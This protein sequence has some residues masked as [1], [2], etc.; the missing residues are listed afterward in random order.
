MAKNTGEVHGFLGRYQGRRLGTLG[1][2]ATLS[3]HETKNIT[4]G[5]GGALLVNDA[6]L[7]KQAEIIR[8]KGTDRARFF[9][10]EVDKYT[11]RAAGSSYLPSDILAAFLLAQLESVDE[12]QGH[13]RRVWSH[14][15]ERLA[16]WAERAGVR[17]PVVPPHCEQTYHMFYLICP[18]AERRR[19]LIA[20]LKERGI[21]AV[22]HYVPLHLSQMGR[23]FGYRPGDFPV[24]EEV[25]ER[26]VRL[27]F[28]SALEEAELEQV[29]D[30]VL[31]IGGR[32]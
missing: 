7:V 24:T 17:L 10:G 27:P 8:E 14:Y 22:F 1:E 21:L 28:Y 23:G 9:R 13:R 29:C 20:G 6:E 31:E 3:F 12:I 11:W 16:P 25:A 26:L 32:W 18:G 15:A 5:E 30:A 2:L 19:E 4:C